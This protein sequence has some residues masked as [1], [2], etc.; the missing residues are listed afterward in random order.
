MSKYEKLISDEQT[1]DITSILAE[2]EELIWKGKP[3]KT[4]FIVNKILQMFPI[5]L[6][7]LACD[8]FFIVSL[9]KGA[10]KELLWFIIPFF[11]FHLLPV[12]TWLANVLSAKKKWE[13]TQYAVTDKRI[14][15]QSGFI[16]MNYQTIFYKDIK[17]VHLRVGI[18]DKL[19][20]SW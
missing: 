14:I 17:N 3:K 18:I 12:W 19:C 11:A 10:P 9:L 20:R 2:G 8:G 4:A 13:N 16:G 15:I 6:I 7:W 5:A 1:V